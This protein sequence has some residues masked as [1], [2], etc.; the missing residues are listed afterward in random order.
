[1]CTITELKSIKSGKSLQVWIDGEEFAE[2]SN[3]CAFYNNLYV[4]AE[5]D[6]FEAQEMFKK[7]RLDSAA[8]EALVYI[9][10]AMHSKAQVRE[11]LQK[12]GYTKDEADYAINELLSY[13]YIDDAE[14]GRLIIEGCINEKKGYYSIKQRL[15]SKG[16]ESELIE[17]LLTDLSDAQ[18]QEA[19]YTIAQIKY[20]ALQDKDRR[21]AAA[22]TS[23]Y[24]SR[25][26]YTWDVINTVMS[27]LSS[28]SGY[29]ED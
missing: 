9:S 20:K 10:R 5:I 6:L 29:D 11:T 12:K 19:A 17:E 22:K 7:D 26:G 1:M 18:Q 8:K 13:G 27:K 21:T 4:G 14:Y 25:N 16:I 3:D 15:K 2:I 24:L 23:Q 28:S